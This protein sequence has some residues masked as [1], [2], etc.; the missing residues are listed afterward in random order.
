MRLLLVQVTTG[1]DPASNRDHVRAAV[2]A[3]L[4]S[5]GPVDLVVLPEAA[6]RDF[7]GGEHLDEAAEPLDGPFVGLLG[8]LAA[9]AG[10]TVVGGMF[11]R[12]EGELPFNTLVAVDPAGSLTATYRKV[13]L[14]DAFG[15]R[16]SDRLSAGAVSA[17][18][19]DVA[20]R[21]S[22]PRRVGLST[23]YDLRF[24]EQYRALADAGAELV[25]VPAAWLRGPAK[26]HHWTTL[27]AAR[28][29]ENTVYV[30]GVA[31]SGSGYCGLTRLP[32]PM[33]QVVA[34]LGEQDGAVAGEVDAARIDAV[35][36]V[37]PSLVNR[38][39][40]VVPAS[41]H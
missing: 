21:D 17:V 13:H 31:K 28:A 20:C 16:E 27:L 14:Y 6:Q 39:W 33:G 25:V 32:D 37:N 38:R 10:A 36:Q 15:Y 18:T 35:R 30:A 2:V 1:L 22:S 5:S 23:C 12:V 26:E 9:R 41:A 34:G 29:I 40:S 8:E 19:V 4:A 3:G 11:E 24:C 7:G